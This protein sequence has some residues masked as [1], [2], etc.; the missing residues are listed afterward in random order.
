MTTTNQN[1]VGDDILFASEEVAGYEIKPL[2]FGKLAKLSPMILAL[3]AKMSANNDTASFDDAGS[4]MGMIAENLEDIIPI[5]AKYLDVPVEEVAETTPEKGIALAYAM[6]NMNRA[7]L[8][9][10]FA[11]R[12]RMI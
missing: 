12:A 10:F 8:L 2:S 7:V 5:M 6:F 4:I 11:V 3:V 9:N 1:P